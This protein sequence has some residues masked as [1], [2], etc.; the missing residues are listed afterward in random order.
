LEKKGAVA[1]GVHGLRRGRRLSDYGVQLRE[2]QKAKR[3]YG[4]REKQFKK[5][6]ERARKQ[7]RATGEV[8]FQLLESRLD[9]IVY[10]LGLA[11][12]RAMARQ[13]ITHGHVVAEG[14][15]VDVPSYEV[16]MGETVGLSP[17]GANIKAIKDYLV[18]KDIGV[19]EW[20][21]KKATMGK[22]KRLP[23]REELEAN[24]NE[25]AIVEYYSR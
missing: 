23:K 22:I 13:L 25:Q 14:K 15:K 1:P 9:N 18:R 20:L 12:S 4:V 8:L 16:K 24:I 3:L 21:E 5:Y 11:P 2:K 19:P 10:R 17:Q 7:P 6:F